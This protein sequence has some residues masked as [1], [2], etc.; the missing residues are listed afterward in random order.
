[1]TNLN[2]TSYILIIHLSAFS[3]SLAL[4][5]SPP[6]NITTNNVDH[7]GR[8]NNSTMNNSLSTMNNHSKR[9]C[10][11]TDDQ[12]RVLKQIFESEPY[13]SQTTLDLLVTQ[14][15]LPMNKIINWF[16]N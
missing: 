8:D 10:L 15:S 7:E 12:R 4:R 5:R 9:R 11:F 14:L 1:M 13:P 2:L 6:S 3:L 16:H